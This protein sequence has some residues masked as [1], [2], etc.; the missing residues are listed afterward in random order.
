M[1]HLVKSKSKTKP[2]SVIETAENGEVLSSHNLKTK[3]ACHKN[4]VARMGNIIPVGGISFR[5]VVQDETKKKVETYHLLDSG[6][7]IPSKKTYPVYVPGKNP[8][9]SK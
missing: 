4:L 1:F 5:V 8:K 7:M 2:F 9:P 6:A 3:Q